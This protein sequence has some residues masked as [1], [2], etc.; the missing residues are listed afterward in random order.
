M[1]RVWSNI[2]PSTW[3]VYP[4][5]DLVEHP[6]L[7]SLLHCLQAY[8]EKVDIYA[9]GMCILEMLTNDTPYRECAGVAQIYAAVTAKVTNC[10]VGCRRPKK[11][12]GVMPCPI[13]HATS[14]IYF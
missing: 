1:I 7:S 4:S 14:S 13:G 12:G 6:S 11:K 9:F 8:D 2:L 10:A 3:Y 5:L